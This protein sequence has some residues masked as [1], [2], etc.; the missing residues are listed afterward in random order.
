M[1]RDRVVAGAVQHLGVHL[2]GEDVAV[3]AGQHR[4]DLRRQLRR[5]D[6]AGRVRGRVQDHEP[7]ARAEALGQVV[8]GEREP[9]L[10][11]Q[12]QRHR[13]RAC[14]ADDRLVDR[15][16]GVRVDDLVAGLAGG[17]HAEEQEGLRPRGDQHAARVDGHAAMRRQVRRAR[18]AQLGQPGRRAVVGVAVA[19]RAHAGLD[20]VL[21]RPEVGLADLEVDH[22]PAGRLE[23]L[24]P[25]QH[26][27]RGLGPEPAHALRQPDCHG[28]SFC[29]VSRRARSAACRR[30]P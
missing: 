4:G 25:R 29:P 18:L 6:P 8:R 16:P 15:E 24:R 13:R 26:L 2:V 14:E 30:T 21:R 11:D 5:D 19:Q 10:L 1:G 3:V 20:D 27:E 22:A 17:E 12:R 23:R 28:R 7:C 9:A